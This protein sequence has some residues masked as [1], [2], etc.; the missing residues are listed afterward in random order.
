MFI[1]VEEK[2]DPVNDTKKQWPVKFHELQEKEVFHEGGHG[3]LCQ[4][5][6]QS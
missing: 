5:L 4:R 3:R 6:L 2:E 1:V